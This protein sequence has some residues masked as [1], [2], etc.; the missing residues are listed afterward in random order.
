MKA[1]NIKN[2]L[3]PIRFGFLVRPTD[4][5]S[6]AEI[7][8]VNTCLWGGMYN[9]I[10]PV[11]NRTP[12]WWSD[13]GLKR[14]NPL[15]ALNR[16]L[17]FFEPDV[18]VECEDGLAARTGY[19]DRRII[20]L[21]QLLVDEEGNEGWKNFGQDVYD[22]YQY[23]YDTEYKYS[24]REPQSITLVNG[25]SG[26][27]DM[28]ASCLFG[29]FTNRKNYTYYR[30]VFKGNFNPNEVQLDASVLEKIYS[31]GTLS[32]LKIANTHIK[33]YSNNH[34]DP[35]LFIFDFN[36]AYD[37]VDFWNLRA[38]YG[39]RI[40]PIP[41]Q[42]VAELSDFCQN[43]ILKNYRPL[44]GNRNGVMI[45]PTAM[46]S[47]SITQV[48]AETIFVSHIR[49]D[50]EGANCMQHWYPSF[51]AKQYKG[52]ARE[53]KPLLIAKE[54]DAE[55]SIDSSEKITKVEA[56]TPDF[57][58][59]HSGN[60][61]WVNVI[62]LRNWGTEPI[63]TVFPIDFRDPKFPQPYMG[64][65][66]SLPTTEGLVLIPRTSYGKNYI[67]IESC[68]TAFSKWLK[69]QNI[70]SV[71]SDAGRATHQIIDTLGGFWGVRALTS[72]KVVEELNKIAMK[73]ASK[74]ENAMAFK[75]KII[76]ASGGKQSSFEKLVDKG[77][78]EIGAEVKCS[79]CGHPSWYDLPSLNHSLKCDLCMKMFDFPKLDTK[80]NLTWAYRLIGPFALPNFAKGG[81]SAA[82]SIRFFSEVV[83]DTSFSKISWASGRELT[84]P[85]KKIIE[86]DYLL[87]IQQTSAFESNS[88]ARLI[89]GESKSFAKEAIGIKDVKAMKEL[90]VRHPGAVLVFSV[91]KNKLSAK[92]KTRLAK[93][94][95]W[96]REIDKKAGVQRATVVILTGL[97]LFTVDD[98]S[99][100]DAWVK[101]TNKH[102]ELAELQGYNLKDLDVLADCTQQI[103]L[104]LAS[105]SDWWHEKFN[106]RR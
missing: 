15:D 73:P 104:G 66:I 59:K 61:K 53:Q 65:V 77:V 63:N 26:A 13:K 71:Q 36:K 87:W 76:K 49:V 79:D 74:T 69:T 91:L 98:F 27:L 86:A 21:D 33:S 17:D 55:Y 14:E 39:N 2:R 18:L 70:S 42:W 22:L 67:E 24:H 72:Q 7:F 32:P 92:E 45:N 57:V 8:K 1:I 9:P 58:E 103:Y 96:G 19:N 47:R 35:S 83:G 29:G 100:E 25:K 93:L 82:L 48:E 84:Y 31:N 90:A 41:K 54:K 78:V 6:I 11:F 89:I 68:S 102:K 34:K 80:T 16:Y 101:S 95:L 40:V 81:Y 51:N 38:V 23:L 62:Q 97:E 88:Q 105:Y 43:F 37:L 20:K 10:I 44:P 56:L 46:F 64:S 5:A 12:S 85:D 99:L 94:A 4:K 28:T 50:K 30:S 3:R 52:I 106:S 60:H 75:N